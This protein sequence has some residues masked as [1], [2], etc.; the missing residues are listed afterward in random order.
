MTAPLR[1][2]SLFKTWAYAQALS[3]TPTARIRRAIVTSEAHRE[4][5]A[6]IPVT[7]PHVAFLAAADRTMDRVDERLKVLRRAPPKV[8]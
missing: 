7:L 6:P 3:Q 8:A 5:I 4:M 2:A 1:I